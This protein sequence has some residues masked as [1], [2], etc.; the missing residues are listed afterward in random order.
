[1]QPGGREEKGDGFWVL[2][3]LLPD[4]HQVPRVKMLEIHMR[5]SHN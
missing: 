3:V 5:D 1:M 2:W 4:S